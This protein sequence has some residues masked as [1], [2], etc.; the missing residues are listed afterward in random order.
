MMEYMDIYQLKLE[1]VGLM[2]E[3]YLSHYK[4]AKEHFPENEETTSRSA[5]DTSNTQKK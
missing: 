2:S 5:H 3:K 1:C 4:S